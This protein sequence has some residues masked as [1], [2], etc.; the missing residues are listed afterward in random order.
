[1]ALSHPV[2]RSLHSQSAA[3]SKSKHAFF[4]VIAA[5]MLVD[6]SSYAWSQVESNSLRAAQVC[7]R[8]ATAA[9][10]PVIKL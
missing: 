4:H 5:E 3:K 8:V 1:M 2:K 7:Q 9:R 10:R 6:Y